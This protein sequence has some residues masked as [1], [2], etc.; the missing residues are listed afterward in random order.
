MKKKSKKT[1]FSALGYAVFF[2]TISSVVSIAVLIYS[3]IVE[4]ASNNFQVALIML[5]VI[6]V[7]STIFTIIDM[8]RRKEMIEK[9]VK[10]ILEATKKIAKG[11]F[12]ARLSPRHSL[13]SFD[14]FDF[15]FENI[16]IMSAELEKNEVLKSDFIANVSHEIKTPL[17]IIQN[18]ANALKDNSLNEKTKAE[19]SSILILATKRITNLVENILKLNKLENQTLIVEKKQINLGEMLRECVLSF[20][21]EIEKKSINL[22]CEIDDI[23]ILSDKSYLQL[24]WNNLLSNAIKFSKVGGMI[25]VSVK[26]ENGFAV[27]K[28]KDDGIGMNEETGRRIFDKFYQGDT[29]HSQEGNGLGLALVKKVIDVIGGIVSVESQVGVG[30]EFTVKLHVE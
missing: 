28:I 11:D 17:A 2:I 9:P 6:L 22:D 20:E 27:V 15:I 23:I 26:S 18:Y 14:E 13:D 5:A 24:I 10:K 7:L 29:S 1:S 19:Y 8:V 21:D 25:N 3:K 12:S 4:S 16:N 30:S